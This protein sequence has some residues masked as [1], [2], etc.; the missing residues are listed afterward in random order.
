MKNARTHMA[1][2]I[3]LLMLSMLFV[4]NV[5]VAQGEAWTSLF[6]GKSL[7]GWSSQ[8]EGDVNVEDGGMRKLQSGATPATSSSDSPAFTI[9]SKL[10]HDEALAGA[11]D[12]ELSG[13]FAFVPGKGGSNAVVDVADM[14]KPTLLGVVETRKQFG[15]R[16]PHDVDR[17]GDYIVIVDPENFAPPLGRLGIFKVADGGNLQPTDQW[18]LMGKTE[19]KALIGANRVQVSGDYAIVGGSLS[20]KGRENAG[21]E[22]ASANMTVVDISSPAEPTIVSNLPFADARGPNGLT[23]AGDVV[24]FAGGQT[25][26]AVDIS[27]PTKPILMASQSFPRF[28]KDAPKTDNYHDLIYRDGY[29]YVSAQTDNGFLIMKVNDESIRDKASEVSQ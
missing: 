2:G 15:L 18:K 14:E 6:D 7:D 27:D 9:V 12:V 21:G 5:C 25:V 19:G 11:H 26:C 22:S 1:V 23:I 4:A 16:Q 17:F 20:I 10:L 29:L 28:K 24:F 8:F 13:D 3:S